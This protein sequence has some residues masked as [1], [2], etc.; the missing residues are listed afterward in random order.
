MRASGAIL[1]LVLATLAVAAH[2]QDSRTYNGWCDSR[3]R[4]SKVRS[5][6]VESQSTTSVIASWREPAGHECVR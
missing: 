6:R 1:L 3:R 5:L 4:P 2:A